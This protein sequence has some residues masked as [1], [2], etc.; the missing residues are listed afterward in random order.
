MTVR[1]RA[2]AVVAVAAMSAI[3]LVSAARPAG[4][5]FQRVY[6]LKPAEGVFAYARISPDGKVL[7]Y[8]SETTEDS[9]MLALKRTQTV[10]DLASQR[11][12]FTEPGIDAYWSND[13]ARMIFLSMSST[14]SN[15]SMRHQD[16]GEVTRGVAP[17]PL[18]DYF[19][20]AV[21][22]G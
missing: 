5:Q 2:V 10:V 18:G 9:G 1:Q 19:S 8:A 13:G 15:V 21:R 7:A 20:W 4:P 3:A 6:P 22:D 14:G 17:V 12:L 16:T 11:I